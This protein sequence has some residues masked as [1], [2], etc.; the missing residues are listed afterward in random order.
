VRA[1]ATSTVEL[2]KGEFVTVW[3]ER[4][5][6]SP[7]AVLRKRRVVVGVWRWCDYRRLLPMLLFIGESLGTIR[8]VQGRAV[9]NEPSYKGRH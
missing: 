6:D 8:R 2:P 7:R 4:P 9:L 3:Y 1:S 5:K